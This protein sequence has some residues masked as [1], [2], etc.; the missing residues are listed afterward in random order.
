MFVAPVSNKLYNSHINFQSRTSNGDNGSSAGSSNGLRRVPVMVLIAM[1]PFM[2]AKAETGLPVMNENLNT[3]QVSDS[4]S[5]SSQDEITRET[6]NSGYQKCSFI[7]YDTDDNKDN[8]EKLGFRYSYLSEGGY[9]GVAGGY[10]TSV[11]SCRNSNKTYYATFYEHDSGKKSKQPKLVKVP[12]DFGKYLLNFAKS[13]ANNH[14]IYALPKSSYERVFGVDSLKTAPK[15]EDAV[16]TLV[17]KEGNKFP[18]ERP[19]GYWE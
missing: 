7:K 1:S 15:I 2:P 19:D 17:T 5:N 4:V 12:E 10:F 14:A 18:Q 13:N 6:V 8:A 16:T 9:Q 11:C 3:V